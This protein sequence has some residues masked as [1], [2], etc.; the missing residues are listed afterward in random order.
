MLI[1]PLGELA[2]R[3]TLAGHVA[4]YVSGKWERLGVSGCGVELLRQMSV[5]TAE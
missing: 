5:S 2:S 4:A 1:P 3:Q